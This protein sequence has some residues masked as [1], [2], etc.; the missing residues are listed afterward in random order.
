MW[1]DLFSMGDK[2][3]MWMAPMTWVTGGG[4][5]EVVC[6]LGRGVGFAYLLFRPVTCHP[7]PG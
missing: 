2:G 5:W 4:L 1:R 7:Q 3:H 6:V